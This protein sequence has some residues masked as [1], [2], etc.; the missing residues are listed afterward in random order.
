[1]NLPD[2]VSNMREKLHDAW[3]IATKNLKQAQNKMK[4]RHDKRAKNRQFEVGEKVLALLPV[5]YQPLQ[6][7]YSG[8]YV[9]TKKVS[10]VDYVID[11][12]DRQK[13]Q[14]MCHVNMLK[15]YQQ[16]FVEIADT[17]NS[18][19]TPSVHQYKKMTLVQ[20]LQSW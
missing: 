12:P 17:T 11:T 4:I 20:Y 8:P 6:A 13:S 7:W 5:P 2:Y 1:M 19:E 16:C 10:E 18:P 9:I 15:T 3:D 14:R